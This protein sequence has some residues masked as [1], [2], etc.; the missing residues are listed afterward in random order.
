MTLNSQRAADLIHGF[1]QVAVDQTGG[2]QRSF[3]LAVYVDEVLLSLRPRLKKARIEIAVDC[4][5]E[6]ILNSLPGAVSQVL[7]NLIM[8]SL[9]HA[10]EPGQ[11]GHI[12][13]SAR[14]ETDDQV[15]LVYGDDGRG[16]PPELHA[17]VFE[18]F[19]TTRRSKGGSGLGLHIVHTIVTQS[20]KGSLAFTSQ[21]DCG[22][23]FTLRLPRVLNSSSQEL[24][25]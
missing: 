7:T 21:P 11:A 17:K 14:L 15:T 12:R 23:E 5:D 10:F 19:F 9:V 3:D 4:P 13:I 25:K 8:N 20:L 16:I 22:V 24:S 1:K 18:P 6:L 2:E